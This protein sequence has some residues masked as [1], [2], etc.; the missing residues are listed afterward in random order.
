MVGQSFV[1][2]VLMSGRLVIPSRPDYSET[3]GLTVDGILINGF[4]VPGIL[5][6]R[7]RVS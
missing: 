7:D 4:L 5:Q 3:F 1:F 6:N 2:D